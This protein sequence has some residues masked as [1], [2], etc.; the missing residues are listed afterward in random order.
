MKAEAEKAGVHF[1]GARPTFT[2]QAKKAE[3]PPQQ[4]AAAEVKQTPQEPAKSNPA[5]EEKKAA[6][7]IL[8]REKPQETA[9]EPRQQQD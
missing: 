9:A 2:K 8:Q 5:P 1:T 6:V 3:E 4:T 7:Q